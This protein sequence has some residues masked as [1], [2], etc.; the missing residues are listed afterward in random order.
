MPGI[1]DRGDPCLCCTRCSL[2]CSSSL[3]RLCPRRR[4]PHRSLP[5]VRRPRPRHRP[6]RSRR[7]RRTARVSRGV[8]DA[9]L[10]SRVSRLAVE[11]RT[12]ARLTARRAA[13]AARPRAVDRTQCGDSARPPRR[14]RAVSDEVRAVVAAFLTD[15]SGLGAAPA[16]DPLAFAVE[17]A[18]ARGLQLHAWFNPVPRHA[19]GRSPVRPAS[20]HV[21]RQHPEWIRK[22]GTQTWI[23]PGDPAARK[24]VLETMLDVVQALRRRRHSHRR[25]LL[26]VSRVARRHASREQEARPRHVEIAFPDDRT[27]KKY[28][29]AAG[30]TDRDAWRRANI[31]D[32]VHSL[33]TGVKAIKPTMLVGISPFGI[34]RPGSPRGRH[35]AR[36]VQRDLRRL[37]TLARRGLARL[38]RAA[39]LLAGRRRAGSLSRARLVVAIRESVKAATSGRVST[40]RTSMADSTVADG[41]DRRRRSRRFATRAS[42]TAE[43]RLA[44]STFVWPRSSP[45]TIASRTAS[46]GLYA[47]TRA[48]AGVPLARRRRTGGSVAGDRAVGA[49]G[50]R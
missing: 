30:F 43:V 1:R 35:R 19:S 33:Y 13:R 49:D 34:W 11:A 8:G 21:T 40:R 44:T 39:A 16:Y 28:G 2:G 50:R 12:V 20:T 22:Y 23:D 14:R 24:Y 27:W 10:G 47:R 3:T 7:R 41:R 32:F 37:E 25:L 31:D 5:P 26:S 48:R 36:L 46:R 17:E 18:H 9:D 45:T 15:K 6:R 4:S 38:P 42:A 29:S